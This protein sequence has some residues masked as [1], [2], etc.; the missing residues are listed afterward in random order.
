MGLYVPGSGDLLLSTQKTYAY[1]P[2]KQD[3]SVWT[4]EL[5]SAALNYTYQA[6]PLIEAGGIPDY[7]L[8]PEHACAGVQSMINYNYGSGYQ[9]KF[10]DL[11]KRLATVFNL[12]A[13]SITNITYASELRD[14]LITSRAEGKPATGNDEST[15]LLIKETVD[16]DISESYDYMLDIEYE[17]RN[18]SRIMATPVLKEIS[19][20]FHTAKHNH[21]HNETAKNPLRFVLYS[22]SRHLLQAIL[23]QLMVNSDKKVAP[24]SSVILFELFK[25]ASSNNASDIDYYVSLSYNTEIKTTIPYTDFVYLVGNNTYSDEQF[26]SY[27][28][29]YSRPDETTTI[30][31]ILILI[32]AGSV[33]G[34]VL[35]GILVFYLRMK[36][37]GDGDT[38]AEEEQVLKTLKVQLGVKE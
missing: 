1:P 25:N 13:G 22:G 30:N 14:A 19:K 38:E 33:I 8:D 9:E 16:I 32:I 36:C 24:H 20:H 21:L 37:K 31:W 4:Q 27:C 10:A 29:S 15:E 11:Y 7:L 18:V 2:N 28:S 5:E 35:I 6:I 26:N 12:P 23:Q 17:G 3:Y 34:L